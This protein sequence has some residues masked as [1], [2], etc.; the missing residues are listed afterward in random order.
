M[1]FEKGDR[2]YYVSGRHSIHSANPVKGS[3]YEC[4]GT[5]DTILSTYTI[6]VKWDNGQGNVY[7]EDDL[8]LSEE[9]LCQDNPNKL[10]KRRR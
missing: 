6:S 5:V 9:R 8:E 7:S 4:V 3:K 10:F 2:V 1:R